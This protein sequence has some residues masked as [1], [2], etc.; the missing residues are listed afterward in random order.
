MPVCQGL[1]DDVLEGERVGRERFAEATKVGL[2]SV[3]DGP[4]VPDPD[5]VGVGDVLPGL[6]RE[7]IECGRGF[8][9]I[10]LTGGGLSV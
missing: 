10:R 7:V 2:H 4:A 1:A 8:H 5:H 9:V 6:E 3:G